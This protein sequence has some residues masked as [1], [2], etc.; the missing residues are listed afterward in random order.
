MSLVSKDDCLTCFDAAGT[1][2]VLS[3]SVHSSS[4]IKYSEIRLLKFGTG[5]KLMAEEL[6][7]TNH[8]QASREAVDSSATGATSTSLK[9][10]RH[11][12]WLHFCACCSSLFT[13]G[14]V[15]GSSGPLIPLMQE[16]FRGCLTAAAINVYFSGKLAFGKSYTYLPC[17]KPPELKAIVAVIT[18][19]VLELRCKTVKQ[20]GYMTGVKRNGATKMGV[21]HAAYGAGALAAPLIST[22]FSRHPSFWSYFYIVS[23]GIGILNVTC[24]IGT[25]RFKGREE[26]LA[27]EGE[28][29]RQTAELDT[30]RD[31]DGGQD[32][33]QTEEVHYKQILKSQTVILIWVEVTQGNWSVSYIISQRNGGSASGYVSAG[34]FGVGRVLLLPVNKWLGEE[35]AIYV[36]LLICVGF[37]LIVWL[38]PSL[39]TGAL[40]ISFIGV[41]LGPFFPIAMNV[42]GRTLPPHILAGSIGLTTAFSA[43]GAAIIPFITGAIAQGAGIWSLQPL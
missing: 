16:Q 20:N 6:K 11:R 39:L 5:K 1:F 35:R 9:A 33:S 43:T 41:F 28:G 3:S 36:Y 42:C 4:E 29:I 30:S 24:L 12:S 25:F 17:P 23:V 40:F 10:Q 34:F 14:W 37:Q 7:S 26:C 19:L 15:D 13:I 27:E 8:A 38:V 21:M 31:A 2:G 32:T 22:Q 18:S